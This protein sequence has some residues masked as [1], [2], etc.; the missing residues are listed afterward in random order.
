MHTSVFSLFLASHPGMLQLI[1]I[2]DVV[3]IHPEWCYHRL[4]LASSPCGAIRASLAGRPIFVFKSVQ[5]GPFGSTRGH[6]IHD[7][8]FGCGVF[9]AEADPKKINMEKKTA[10]STASIPCPFLLYGGASAALSFSPVAG[11]PSP[12]LRRMAPPF[13]FSP[14]AGGS[15]PLFPSAALPFS[16]FRGSIL[17][18]VV[19]LAASGRLDSGYGR[20]R[21]SSYSSGQRSSCSS[22]R[23]QSSSSSGRWLSSS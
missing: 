3:G 18:T 14:T 7:R 5:F 12:S 23:R 16:L 6:Q 8:P 20:R 11:H 1:I 17:T 10:T 21:R 13:P 22:E 19:D 15:P 9:P 4:H 2:D